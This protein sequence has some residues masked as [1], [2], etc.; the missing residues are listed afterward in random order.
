[1]VVR[2]MFVGSVKLIEVNC[3]W[4]LHSC[5]QLAR[6]N[7]ASL[8]MVRLRDGL[9]VLKYVGHAGERALAVAGR[10]LDMVELTSF[11]GHLV[12]LVYRS[13]KVMW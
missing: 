9:D 7:A 1:M 6:V 8:A 12:L 4:L 2:Q 10:S 3:A 13:R 5:S 11:H